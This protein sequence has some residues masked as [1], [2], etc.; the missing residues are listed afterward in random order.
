LRIIALSFALDSRRSVIARVCAHHGS[1]VLF[2]T[3]SGEISVPTSIVE[4]VDSDLN[5]DRD[6]SSIAVGDWFL[7]TRTEHRGVRRL[8][9]NTVLNRKAAGDA[10][11]PQLIAAN[12][13]TVFIVSSCNQDFNPSR[14]ERYLALVLESGATPVVILTKADLCED[15]AALRQIAESLHPG[16]IVETL[17]IVLFLIHD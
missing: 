5:P 17:T 4:S 1:F 3:Q 8:E 10:A 2:L 13:D 14:I 6:F 16:L 12:V 15:P 11:K 9:R 7:L